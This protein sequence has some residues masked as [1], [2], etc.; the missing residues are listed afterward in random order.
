MPP[1][2]W[3]TVITLVETESLVA[4]AP[5]PGQAY[6]SRGRFNPPAP[7]LEQEP[8]RPERARAA[9]AAAP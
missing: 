8:G 6:A 1:V 5:N 9:V 2:A 4:A 3:A 7:G